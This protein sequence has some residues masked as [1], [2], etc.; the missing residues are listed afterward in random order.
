MEDDGLN[1]INY[2]VITYTEE[3]LYTNITV[4]V[5][6]AYENLEITWQLWVIPWKI[7]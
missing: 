6:T 5:N 3:K 1:D 4:E 2:R 7:L